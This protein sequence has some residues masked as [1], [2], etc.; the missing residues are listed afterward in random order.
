MFKKKSLWILLIILLI[1]IFIAIPFV[2]DWCIIGNQVPSNISNSDWVGF[3][4]GYIGSIISMLGIIVTIRFT[5]NQDKRNQINQIRPYTVLRIIPTNKELKVSKV[6]KSLIII[7]GNSENRADL[8]S[9]TIMIKNIGLGPAVDFS[10][11][12]ED[13]GDNREHF[14]AIPQ[15]SNAVKNIAVNSLQPGEEAAL[16]ID[17]YFNFD[18]IPDEAISEEYDD[19]LKTKIKGVD[20]LYLKKYASFNIKTTINFFDMYE[21]QY[22]QELALKAKITPYIDAENHV[23]LSGELIVM[24][25]TRP[26]IRR[27][28]KTGK[29]TRLHET[30]SAKKQK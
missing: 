8:Y 20:P 23:V 17:V 2:I 4:S 5:Y 25:A 15:W 18:P 1:V 27:K 14:G 9:C 21:N 12:A 11:V 10:F 13:E 3:L 16:S 22:S 6:F 26:E 24:E 19:L 29:R 7:C 30:T 28:K